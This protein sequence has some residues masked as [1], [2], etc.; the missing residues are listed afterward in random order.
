MADETQS[1]LPHEESLPPR[2][3]LWT[4]AAFLALG[5][6]IVSL[7]TQMPT[8]TEQKGEIYTAPGLVP[9]IYGLVISTLSIWLI[10]RSLRRSRAGELVESEAAAPDGSSNL[11]LALAAALG[12]VFC[13]G[14]IGRMPFW[15][16]AAIFVTAFIALFEWRKG[17]PWSRRA[18]RFGTAVLQGLVTGG[19]VMLVFEKIFYVRLP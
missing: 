11:R 2:V 8:F 18:M 13:V 14:L 6:A 12:L 15:A 3:D 10:V 7:A 1:V 4:G 16:A 17:D 9:G 19:L 5:L